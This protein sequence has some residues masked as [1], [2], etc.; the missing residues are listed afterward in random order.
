MGGKVKE[1]YSIVGGVVRDDV[2]KFFDQLVQ[3]KKFESRSKAVAYVLTEYMKKYCSK[4]DIDEI[5]LKKNCA[6]NQVKR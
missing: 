6:S 3:E 4:I 5:F 1:G 2:K